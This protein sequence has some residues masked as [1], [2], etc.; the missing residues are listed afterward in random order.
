[1]STEAW[2]AM[3]ANTANHTLT[4]LHDDGLYRHLRMSAGNSI[5]FSW[6]II[7]WPGSLAIRGDIGRELVFTRHTDM[8]DFFRDP[9][10]DVTVAGGGAPRINPDYWAEK[11]KTAEL[12]TFELEPAM[13][14]VAEHMVDALTWSTSYN[15]WSENLATYCALVE[16]WKDF[17][18]A[19]HIGDDEEKQ[20]AIISWLMN[21]PD[22]GD[23][24]AWEWDLRVWDYNYLMTCYAIVA[25][26][27]AWDRRNSANYRGEAAY[28]EYG[29]G[30]R[31]ASGALRGVIGYDTAAA[32]A[33]IIEE[34]RRADHA[35]GDLVAA[36]RR[37]GGWRPVSDTELARA[38]ADEDE[39]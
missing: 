28:L 13:A 21:N 32:A 4:V 35:D 8:L 25:T 9:D 15:D 31:N 20:R 22:V 16:A 36:V 38:V 33:G 24:D 5:A 12:K 23:A 27:A 37:I 26:V 34:N 10:Y 14:E 1:M 39:E 18:S 11:T 3:K 19:C 17:R 29:V 6:D 30:Y 7:T 2:L